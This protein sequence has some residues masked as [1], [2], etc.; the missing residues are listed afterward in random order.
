MS[1][2]SCQT[3]YLCM[4]DWGSTYPRV[5]A[6]W[7]QGHDFTDKQVYVAVTHGGSRYGHMISDFRKAM[8][9]AT[10]TPLI[11]FS[12]WDLDDATEESL[13]QEVAAALSRVNQDGSH[14][15]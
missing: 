9:G 4:P 1:L 2:N 3:F 6:S 5:F 13:Q 10:V 14:I 8:P 11:E 7:M 15:L 12:D